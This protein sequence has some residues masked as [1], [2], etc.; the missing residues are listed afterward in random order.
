MK[1]L[2]LLI[3]SKD[4]ET[5]GI[6]LKSNSRSICKKT[7]LQVANMQEAYTLL[8]RLNLNLL[9]VDVDSEQLDLSTVK[10]KFP[11]LLIIGMSYKRSSSQIARI[12]PKN[13]LRNSLLNELKSIRKDKDLSKVNRS[14]NSNRKAAGSTDFKDF[15][16][17]VATN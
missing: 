12:L 3:V 16:R 13:D 5:K 15:F 6:V 4:R 7:V 14:A 2:N 10:S 9:L 11:D 1:Q 17:L 8:A